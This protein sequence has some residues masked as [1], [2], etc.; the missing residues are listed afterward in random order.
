MRKRWRNF[1]LM[2]LLVE[3]AASFENSLRKRNSFRRCA[4]SFQV[5]S[6]RRRM[7]VASIAAENRAHEYAF[8]VDI[9]VLLSVGRIGEGATAT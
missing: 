2:D 9:L 8:L 3:L 5:F 4:V 7:G 1:Y 6:H